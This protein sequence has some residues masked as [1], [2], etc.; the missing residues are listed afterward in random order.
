MKVPGGKRHIVV[1]TRG[2]PLFVGVAPAGVHDS[3]AVGEVFFRLRLIHPELAVVWTDS[4]CAGA[5]VDGAE[6]FRGLAVRAVSRP[7]G[8]QGL[9]ILPL[10]WV[11]ERSLVWLLHCR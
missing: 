11:V 4:A 6:F 2:L 1:D 10:R 3:V 8:A 5:P 7:K 9:V